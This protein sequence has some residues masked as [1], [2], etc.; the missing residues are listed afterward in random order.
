MTTDTHRNTCEETKKEYKRQ[1]KK[2]GERVKRRAFSA[3]QPSCIAIVAAADRPDATQCTAK[4]TA[5]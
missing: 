3:R 2:N 1:Q 4:A 5:Q